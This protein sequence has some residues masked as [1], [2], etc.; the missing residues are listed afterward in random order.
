MQIVKNLQVS[1]MFHSLPKH[2][3]LN[4]GLGLGL[5]L[6]F[7]DWQTFFIIREIEHDHVYGTWQML[8]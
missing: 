8:L 7:A 2:Q 6:G 5:G 3:Y 1:C 4:L